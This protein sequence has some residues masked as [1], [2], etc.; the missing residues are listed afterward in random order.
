MK[1]F[2]PDKAMKTKIIS[3]IILW[4]KNLEDKGGSSKLHRPKI[5]TKEVIRML[6][7]LPGPSITFDVLK[8]YWENIPTIQ[9]RIAEMNRDT[10]TYRI[11]DEEK[12]LDQNPKISPD[13][14]PMG[15]MPVDQQSDQSIEPPGQTTMSMDEP[16]ASPAPA[17]NQM[18]R[19]KGSR[20]IVSQMAKRARS[21]A[22]K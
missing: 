6:N 2:T 12:D 11:E 17:D 8:K 10:V 21:R 5:K 1:E 19:L 16:A 20:S 22:I 18:N 15:D 13:Q 3:L 14:L 4:G 9:D 7:A